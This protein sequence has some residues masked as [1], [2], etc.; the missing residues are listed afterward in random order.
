[1]PLRSNGKFIIFHRCL[2]SII[3]TVSFPTSSKGLGT[4]SAKSLVVRAYENI[5]PSAVWEWGLENLQDL[6]IQYTTG[7][8]TSE[9]SH[10]LSKS[11]V[12]SRIMIDA[13]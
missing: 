10:L 11:S 1:M 2:Y 9:H 3:D 5:D 7:P 13:I 4:A 12:I 6:A 8:S